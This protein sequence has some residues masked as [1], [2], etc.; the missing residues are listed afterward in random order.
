MLLAGD[1]FGRTSAGNNNAYCQD[2]EINWLDWKQAA[3]PEAGEV[4][5]RLHRTG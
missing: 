2:N 3:S 5:D 4:A 1:E